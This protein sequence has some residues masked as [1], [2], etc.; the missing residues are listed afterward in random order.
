MSDELQTRVEYG[1]QTEELG[2]L[3]EPRGINYATHQRTVHFRVDEPVYIDHFTYADHRHPLEGCTHDRH[4]LTTEAMVNER[5][6]K[7][8]A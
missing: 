3:P 8:D 6:S 7:R 4:D 1:H 5:L 2:W